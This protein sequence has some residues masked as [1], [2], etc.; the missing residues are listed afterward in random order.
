MRARRTDATESQHQT[1]VIDW[2]NHYAPTRGIDPRLLF[3]V[4][5]GSVLAGDARHRAIQMARLKREGLR[6][7]CPDLFLAIAKDSSQIPDR[8]NPK[9]K[10]TMTRYGGPIFNGLFIELKRVGGKPT[11]AQLDYATLLRNQRYDVI[12]AEGADEA[13]RAITAYLT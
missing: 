1:A 9:V 2:F 5:N 3:S 7:G 11:A 13:I 10:Y 12:I 6:A 8:L 4:P